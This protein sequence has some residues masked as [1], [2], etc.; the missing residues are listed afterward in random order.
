[1]MDVYTL[2]FYF[3][4]SEMLKI[5]NVFVFSGVNVVPYVGADGEYLNL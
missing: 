4:T 5:N 2:W 1:M 3:Y